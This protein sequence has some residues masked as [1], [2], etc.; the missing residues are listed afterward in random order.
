[1]AFHIP[2]DFTIFIF[3]FIFIYP[4]NLL[5]LEEL[6]NDD[7]AFL[8][9]NHSTDFQSKLGAAFF[10]SPLICESILVRKCDFVL[11]S[12]TSPELTVKVIV[13]W[14]WF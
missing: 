5:Y 7:P 8:L 14:I 10:L 13:F 3:I 9:S 6:R 12:H 4:A 11:V 1:M 2:S